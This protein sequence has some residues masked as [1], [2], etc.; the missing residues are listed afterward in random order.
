MRLTREVKTLS[1]RYSIIFT[2]V[3]SV[4]HLS[5]AKNYCDGFF[6]IGGKRNSPSTILKHFFLVARLLLT[7]KINSIHVVNEQLMI[8]FYPM[9]LFKYSVLD[10]FDSIFLRLSVGGNKWMLVKWLIYKP[11]NVI[12]TTDENR[13]SLLPSFARKKTIVVGNY[14]MRFNTNIKQ[15]DNQYITIFYY[16]SLNSHRGSDLL[17]NLMK[18]RKDIRVIAAGWV[19]DKANEDLVNSSGIQYLGI[20]SEQ[21][22]LKVASRDCDYIWCLFE[23]DNQNYIYASPNKLYDGIQVETAIVINSEAKISEFV[24]Q[25]NIGVVVDNYYTTEYEKVAQMLIEKKGTFT[26]SHALREKYNWEN[27]EEVL[28]QTH[29]TR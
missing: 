19:Y 5:F 16:G 6:L 13:K 10:I 12:I 27:Q 2:G 8:F 29:D 22:A 21:E 14:P 15:T 17:K 28:L 9:M 3:G 4:S 11:M 20:L 18:V 1:K 25:E 23:P 24:K 7:K 26:F